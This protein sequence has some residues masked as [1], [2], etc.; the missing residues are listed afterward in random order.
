MNI[1]VSRRGPAG[2]NARGSA[3]KESAPRRRRRTHKA[4]PSHS[5][6]ET[7]FRFRQ[8]AA[9]RHVSGLSSQGGITVTDSQ[10]ISPYSVGRGSGSGWHMI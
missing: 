8:N 2:G 3:Q 5:E 1:Y 4:P 10:G 9:N 6:A 7:H